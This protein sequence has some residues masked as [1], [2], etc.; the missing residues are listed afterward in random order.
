MIRFI[1]EGVQGSKEMQNMEH[2][3]VIKQESAREERGG[4]CHKHG[5]HH[6]MKKIKS[7]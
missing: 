1:G 5:G 2:D 7:A 3:M 6:H 4:R